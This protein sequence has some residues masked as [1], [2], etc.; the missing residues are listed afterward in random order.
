VSGPPPKPPKPPKPPRE[1]S[2]LGRITFFAVLMVLGLLALIDVA[3][4]RVP[5]SAYF[6]AALATT[7]L[8]LLVGAWFGR[9]RGLIALALVA[10]LGLVV[11]SGV[12][13]FGG[14]VANSTY[15]PQN[16]SQVADRY[17]FN[18][19]NVTLDLRAVDFTGKTQATTISMKLGQV[20]VLLP[21]NVDTTGT[22]DVGDGRVVLFGNEKDIQN[23]NAMTL[24][25]QGTDGVGGGALQLT[26]QMKA[27]NVEVAR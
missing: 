8:G 4:A 11:S 27:G 1:R 13:R 10:T 5:V 19:G 23:A 7:G 24:N 25:D 12:E 2:K 16:I 21:D 18:L 22:V 26:I 14:Q 17:D 9:A 3:T 6:A 15:R 20:K